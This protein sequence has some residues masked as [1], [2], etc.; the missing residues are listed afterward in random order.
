MWT[1]KNDNR[2]QYF[3]SDLL[4]LK[5][6]FLL[7]PMTEREKGSV[8]FKQSMGLSTLLRGCVIICEVEVRTGL[9]V[10]N[11]LTALKKGV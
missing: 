6:Q 4:V 7:L 8:R 11:D 9:Q 1:G 3:T 10:Y 2:K 5:F